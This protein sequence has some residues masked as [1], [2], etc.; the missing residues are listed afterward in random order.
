MRLERG[1]GETVFTRENQEIE[2]EEKK[3]KAFWRGP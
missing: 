2:T 3:D 1:E